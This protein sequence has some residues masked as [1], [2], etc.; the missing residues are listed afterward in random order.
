MGP[1]QG[2]VT[3]NESSDGFW[4]IATANGRMK[5]NPSTKEPSPTQR[6]RLFAKFMAAEDEKSFEMYREK[7]AKLLSSLRGKV[8]ELGPGTGVNLQFLDPS[9]EWIGV[10]PNPAMHGHIKEKAK[11]HGIQIQ[12]IDTFPGESGIQSESIDAVVSTLVLCSV[13][14]IKSLLADVLRILKPGGKF[15]FI[16]HVADKPWSFRRV[17][18][19][20]VP[21]TPWRY[22]S[23]GCNPGRDISATIHQAGFSSVESTP[24]M[25][26]GPGVILAINRPHIWGTA[27]K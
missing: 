23:D 26:P 10:E 20:T 18:Q 12:I 8:V 11:D 22:F 1:G 14:S 17:I 9:V 24:Y 4:P 5:E 27:E 3:R 15:V 19:K 21:F 6:Q 2:S 7:K 16:E 25:Q 13:P